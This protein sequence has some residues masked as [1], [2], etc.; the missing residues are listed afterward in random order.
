[1][2]PSIAP[3]RAAITHVLESQAFVYPRAA[4]SESVV[5]SRF[6]GPRRDTRKLW[7]CSWSAKQVGMHPL[8]QH[9]PGTV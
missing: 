7:Y 3:V 6:D 8:G 2:T 1:M 9:S 4:Q 5:H